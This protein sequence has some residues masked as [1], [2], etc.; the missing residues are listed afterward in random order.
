MSAVAHSSDLVRP[1]L[2]TVRGAGG[3]RLLIVGQENAAGTYW[4]GLRFSPVATLFEAILRCV[5]AGTYDRVI[6]FTGSSARALPRRF[7]LAANLSLGDQPMIWVAKGEAPAPP[8]GAAASA[9]ADRL[10]WDTLSVLKPAHIERILWSGANQQYWTRIRKLIE[11]RDRELMTGRRS[12]FL[13]DVA[14]LEPTGADWNLFD[15]TTSLGLTAAD[16]HSITD[17]FIVRPEDLGKSDLIVFSESVAAMHLV[18]GPPFLTTLCSAKVSRW[19]DIAPK[20]EPLLP[21]IRLHEAEVVEARRLVDPLRPLLEIEGSGSARLYDL[22]R[23]SAISRRA[24]VAVAPQD[25]RRIALEFWANLDLEPIRRAFDSEIIGQTRVKTEILRL[26]TAHSVRCRRLL[27]ANPRIV[28]TANDREYLP[29][30]I[31]LFGAAGMGKTTFCR[32]LARNL[33]GDESFTR[34]V[35]LSAKLLSTETVGVAPPYQGNDQES[36]LMRFARETGGLGLF[37]FDEFTRIQRHNQ[38][39]ADALSPM[40][41][42]IESRSFTPANARFVPSGGRYYLSNTVFVLSGNLARPDEPTPAGFTSM[43]DLGEAF[44]RRVFGRG[45]VFF[46]DS[47]APENYETAFQ[48]A[49]RR[50]TLRIVNDFYP[51]RG[52]SFDVEIDAQLSR[53]LIARFEESLRSSGSAPSLALIDGMA[54]RLS[55]DRAIEEAVARADN[56]VRLTREVLE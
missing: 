37:C 13:V 49:L 18:D 33:F 14:Y 7:R 47:L 1:L 2:D 24:S 56:V 43:D 40:L 3:R 34:I 52:G 16:S 11:I 26:L 6:A 10:P 15:G 38:T 19:S 35:D 25:P 20:I 48:G 45:D 4:M 44:K 28:R 27:S 23:R 17:Q 29:P 31:G 36:N 41:E 39:L 5:L 55:F 22:L 21:S 32:V 53:E 42:I 12:A 50:H 54:Q 46:F 9:P 51:D 8:S 30:V